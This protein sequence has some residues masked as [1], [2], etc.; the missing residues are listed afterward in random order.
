MEVLDLLFNDEGILAPP[1]GKTTTVDIPNMT[2]VSV[3]DTVTH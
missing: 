2:L 1:V 3:H